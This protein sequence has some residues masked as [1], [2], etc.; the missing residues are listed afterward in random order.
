MASERAQPDATD[1]VV[2]DPSMPAERLLR[3]LRS[4]VDGLSSREARRRLE[5]FGPNRLTRRKHHSWPREIRDQFTHPLALLLL[6][7]AVLA[8]VA[9]TAVLG[10]AILDPA[11]PPDRLGDRRVEPRTQAQVQACRP[12]YWRSRPRTT[13]WRP[14]R[15]HGRLMAHTMSWA[16]QCLLAA[17]Q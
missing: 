5:R 9:H 12:D 8:F 14:Q 4:S 1:P 2:P 6:A 17:G 13:S 7:A 15:G 3:D 16:K 10:W 11:V